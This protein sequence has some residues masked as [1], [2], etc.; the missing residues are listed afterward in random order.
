MSKIIVQK[1]GGSSL[2]D[3]NAILAVAERISASHSDEISIVAV[4][5]AMGST[6]DELTSLASKIN[7]NPDRRELDLLLSTGELVSCTLTSMALQAIGAPSKSLSGWQA[8]IYTDNRYGRAQI[9]NIDISP[10]LNELSVGNIVIIAGFQGI[11]GGS[12]IT[13][14]GRGGSDTTAVAIAAALDA[15]RCEI[16]TDVEGIYSADPRLV[17]TAQKLSHI[18]Y[19]EMLEMASYG[20]KMHP[21]SIE[22]AMTYNVPIY[23]A[24]SFNNNEGTLIHT[25][26][27]SE[28]PDI[29]EHRKKVTSIATTIGYTKFTLTKVPNRAGLASQ[30]FE[31]LSAKNIS[32]DEISMNAERGNTTDLTFTVDSADRNKTNDVLEQLKTDLNAGGIIISDDLAK[33]S[34]IGTGMRE[35]SGYA[36]LMF[37]TLASRN[38]NIDLITTSEIRITCLIDTSDLEDAA[39]SLHEAFELD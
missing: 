36:A 32:V 27:F 25:D 1:Y 14:L 9:K 20:A 24:S 5:S 12:D 6:T 10:I 16:Y 18:S 22:L 29:N 7:R 34:V 13:T 37:T 33:I 3:T 19:E 30:I 26:L 11:D 21:R 28:M 31:P 4:V 35:E 39:K 38:I 15:D 8:G 2:H 23:V 17:P